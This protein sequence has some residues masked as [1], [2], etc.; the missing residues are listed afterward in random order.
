[1]TLVTSEAASFS[2]GTP[3][4]SPGP[5]HKQSQC[6]EAPHRAEAQTGLR[7]SPEHAWGQ[8]HL[9]SP[10]GPSCSS[11]LAATTCGSSNQGALHPAVGGPKRVLGH[12]SRLLPRTQHTPSPTP[13]TPGPA[14][15]RWLPP[16]RGEVRERGRGDDATDIPA[17]PRAR[18]NA[19][20]RVPLSSVAAAPSEPRP[21]T[22][23]DAEAVGPGAQSSRPGGADTGVQAACWQAGGA[24]NDKNRVCGQVPT[25]EV[26]PR[27]TR[28]GLTEETTPRWGF[29][30]GRGV[31]QRVAYNRVLLS[32]CPSLWGILRSSRFTHHSP[33]GGGRLACVL[34]LRPLESGLV[35]SLVHP[36][37]RRGLGRT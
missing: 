2:T 16:L 5:P 3:A 23:K 15:P 35:A 37:R 19:A 14:S 18:P 24:T 13:T 10:Q 9:H 28:K 31:C 22:H 11:Q 21:A 34:A 33:R 12:P 26:L 29:G 32:L 6:L 8:G 17:A 7:R 27:D 36:G 30:G 4:G 20:V 1:M 25:G